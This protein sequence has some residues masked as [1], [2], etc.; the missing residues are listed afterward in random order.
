MSRNLSSNALAS[1]YAQ[2]TGEVWLVLC[3]ITHPALATPLRF[4]NDMQ[5]LTSRGNVYVAFPFEVEL[6]TEDA[7]SPG[8]AR[9]VLDNIDRNIVRAIREM[10]GPPEITLEVVLASAPDTVEAEFPGMVLRD[11]Q[12]DASKVSGTLRFEDITS[13]PISVEMTPQR[14]PAL[15]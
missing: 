10:T 8:E 1:A 9:L 5:S 6:P 12:Y 13:E 7:D 11:T 14:F 3:T 15:F 4:V 2:E